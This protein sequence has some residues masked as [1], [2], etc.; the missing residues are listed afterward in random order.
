[1]SAITE[2]R[3]SHW[4]I[5]KTCVIAF[6]HYEN[7]DVELRIADLINMLRC[8]PLGKAK[9]GCGTP[10]F[11]CGKAKMGCGVPNFECGK[12]ICTVRW[13]AAYLTLG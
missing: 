4:Q 9:M 13:G 8:P 10:N 6:A 12:A 5:V 11:E 7:K 1:M 3:V 2:L